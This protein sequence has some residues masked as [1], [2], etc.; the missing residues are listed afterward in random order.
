MVCFLNIVVFKIDNL[1]PVKPVLGKKKKNLKSF[2]F[3]T[4]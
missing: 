1:M 2:L 3:F 4:F